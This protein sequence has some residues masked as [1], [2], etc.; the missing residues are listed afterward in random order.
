MRDYRY[1]GAL[2]G[3]VLDWAGTTIDYGCIAP[4]LV[5]VEVFGAHGVEVTLDEA[6]GPMGMAKRDH[7]RA[8]LE[9]PRVAQAWQAAHGQAPDE[10][11][12]DGLYAEFVP[13]QMQTILQYS[14]LI[15]GVVETIAA[16]RARGLK[17]GSCTG[18][19]RAMMDALAPIA[20]QAGYAADCIITPQDV[21]QGRPSPYM[22]YANALH[23][24][25]YPLSA[26]VKVGDTVV[27]IEEGRNAG[28]W[29]VGLALTGNEVG[30]SQAE[31]AALPPEQAQA[32]LD[33][34]RRR[35][36]EAGAHYV[37][38]SLSDILPIMDAIEA[39]LS[40]GEQ[41]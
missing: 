29:T 41:P 34:A 24:G 15:P 32:R 9:L 37:I 7:I 1:R 22:I 23:L 20:A 13:R 6:R 3:I 10:A 16:L 25:I 39:R 36:H 19:T 35:L 38:D 11:V 4:T 40:A 17:I 28:C 27:D 12:L 31:W 21:S 18:Y 14:E 2:Q 5:F 33:A 8:V 30:L 26:I